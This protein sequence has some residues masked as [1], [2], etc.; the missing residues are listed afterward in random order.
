MK[1]KLTPIICVTDIYLMLRSR[2]LKRTIDINSVSAILPWL[3]YRGFLAC[4]R[5]YH[6]LNQLIYYILL[7]DRNLKWLLENPP[8]HIIIAKRFRITSTIT[9]KP[10][11]N[12]CGDVYCE[13][14]STLVPRSSEQL[15]V[16]TY[17][18]SE[19][20]IRIKFRVYSPKK[21]TPIHVSISVIQPSC[22]L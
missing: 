21:R 15:Y 9:I 11:L 14:L 4:A 7:P 16:N 12:R 20:P 5:V 18:G 22:L 10:L 17:W 3:S 13:Q 8:S 1:S 6:F 19:E 2:S